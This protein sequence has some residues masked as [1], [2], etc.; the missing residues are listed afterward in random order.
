MCI[1]AGFIG[2]PS[3]SN[4]YFVFAFILLS[5]NRP[6]SY[7]LFIFLHSFT[8]RDNV[9]TR[10]NS[11]VHVRPVTSSASGTHLQK[12]PAKSSKLVKELR[13]PNGPEQQ[14]PRLSPKGQ[15]LQYSRLFF[16]FFFL[17]FIWFLPFKRHNYNI[18]LKIK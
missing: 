17:N 13:I 5:H 18:V 16:L 14:L 7:I 3:G 11:R 4:A 12:C 1:P 10:G 6:V 8:F 9:M 15:P 2:C